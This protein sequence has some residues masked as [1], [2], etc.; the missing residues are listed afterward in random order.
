MKVPMPYSKTCMPYNI[1]WRFFRKHASAKDI[2]RITACRLKGFQFDKIMLWGD[3]HRLSLEVSFFCDGCRKSCTSNISMREV[4]ASK[5][6]ETV[7]QGM[8]YKRDILNSDIK[9]RSADFVVLDEFA[10][11][12]RGLSGEITS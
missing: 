5:I 7:Q 1:I 4:V 8:V 10:H 9:G 11:M 6:L 12:E 3:N 2:A